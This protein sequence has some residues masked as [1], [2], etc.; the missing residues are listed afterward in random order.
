MSKSNSTT[1]TE[2]E[3]RQFIKWVSLSS[4]S[5]ALPLSFT[6][7]NFENTPKIDPTTDLSALKKVFD[8]EKLSRKVMA[9]DALLYLNGGA[10]D[11]KTVQLNSDA[12]QEIQIRARRLIDVTKEHVLIN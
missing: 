9:E 3:R 1:S 4:L 6:S 11:L 12:Y 7:C 10:D 8:F 2:I 5:L